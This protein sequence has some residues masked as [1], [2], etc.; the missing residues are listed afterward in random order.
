M[1]QNGYTIQD[2]ETDNLSGIY[3]SEFFLD[4]LHV[5]LLEKVSIMNSRSEG[6]PGYIF[7]LSP[8]ANLTKLALHRNFDLRTMPDND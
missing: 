5:E 3:M 4:P 8:N 2:L 1:A 7:T 6:G